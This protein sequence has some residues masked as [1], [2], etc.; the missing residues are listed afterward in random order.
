MKLRNI[1]IIIG[2]E[3]STKVKKKSFLLVTFLVPILF[4]AMMVLPT[5]IMMNAKEK[6]QNVAVV[7]QSG[8]VMPRLKNDSK[9][10]YLD[11]TGMD[12]DSVKAKLGDM[13]L[14]MLLSVSTID[15]LSLTFTAE[16]FSSKPI[17]VE[18]R[19]VLQD[20]L[21]AA[22]EDYRIA[23]T[24]IPDL[25]EIIGSVKSD[26][27]LS[28][29][30]LN[31]EGKAEISS[32]DVYMM[33]SLVLGVIIYM[34]IAMFSG[35][36]MSSVIEEKSSRVI[37]VLISSVKATELMIGK[38]VGVALVA[39][40]QFA[41]WIVLTGF[42]LGIVGGFVGFDRIKDLSSQPSVQTAMGSNM[43]GVDVAGVTAA[44]DSVATDG[45][46]MSAVVNTLSSI[47]WGEIILVFVIFFSLGYL[48]YASMLA[49]IGSAVDSAD[50]SQQLSL[51][52]TI[53][54]LLG[55]FIALYT[56]N[57]PDSGLAFWGSI[58]PFTSPIVMLARVPF[59]VPGWQIILSI[60]LLLLTFVVFAWL[61]AKIYKVGI[62]MFGKKTTYKDLWNWLRQK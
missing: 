49:A 26:V 54:L 22:L 50:D 13:G 8:I 24:G 59:G 58:I 55:F 7:D 30:T 15:T 60:V 56:F 10:T 4:A 17:G 43:P 37:E 21:D 28:T 48:L 29:Y 32:S 42:I 11:C 25:K 14:D 9:A 6:T 27:K 36:V 20:T 34:F 62:L 19:D 1:G 41:M 31:E 51:S 33:I 61:S 18:Y 3:Y 39:L 16:T 5:I 38:I 57:A 12:P 52:V 47:N 35:Q 46:E 45:G 53:P 2:R 23:R 40:T 44:V